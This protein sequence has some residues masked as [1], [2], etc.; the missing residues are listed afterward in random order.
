MVEVCLAY[1][2][3]LLGGASLRSEMVLHKNLH[4][5]GTLHLVQQ[6]KNSSPTLPTFLIEQVEFIGGKNALL[7]IGCYASYRS[8][9]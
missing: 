6:H 1:S 3:G 8:W 9:F 7:V 5:L 2:F 4:L